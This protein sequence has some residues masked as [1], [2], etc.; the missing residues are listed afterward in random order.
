LTLV[1]AFLGCLLAF[2]FV[3][4]L[5]YTYAKHRLVPNLIARFRGDP[6]VMAAFQIGAREGRSDADAEHAAAFMIRLHTLALTLTFEQVD[7]ISK[8]LTA[9]QMQT[10]LE[11]FAI[12]G[13]SNPN[14]PNA[15]PP[16]RS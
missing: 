2:L 5:V 16:P 6:D 12:A 15:A 3:L 10:L 7:A 1:A 14:A 8:I 9:A 13:G 4:A 11:V